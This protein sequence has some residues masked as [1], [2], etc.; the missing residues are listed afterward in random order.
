MDELKQF[1]WANR[2]KQKDLA[3]YLGV[4]GAQVS[5]IMKGVSSLT[6]R[7]L[8]A[9]RENQMGWD[10]SML[11]SS[12]ISARATGSSTATITI[13]SNNRQPFSSEEKPSESTINTIPVIP[14][15]AHA[16]RLSDY[17]DSASLFQC[18]MISSPIQGA[19]CAIRIYGDSMQPKYNAGSI[20]FL[21]KVNESV[22]LEWGRTYVLDTDNGAV[23]KQL[24][25]GSKEGMIKCHSLNATY[26]DFEIP[27]DQIHGWYRVL[28]AVVF[29]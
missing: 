23:I 3:Q 21:R 2:L 19:T 1:L 28:G 10:A 16:G 8:T 17:A 25:P 13:G 5:R 7:N 27:A 6:E 24:L 4:T 12:S 18:E 15:D 22:F 14:I 20:A 11:P 26:Q 9:L 29:D